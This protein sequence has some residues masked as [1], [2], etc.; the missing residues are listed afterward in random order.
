MVM[1]INPETGEFYDDGDDN[2]F[3][4][5]PFL[6]EPITVPNESVLLDDY[7]NPIPN[8]LPIYTPPPPSDPALANPIYSDTGGPTDTTSYNSDGTVNPG[9]T[10]YSGGPAD[11][12]L[13]AGLTSSIN[14]LLGSNFTGAQLARMAAVAG[15]GIAGLMGAFKPSIN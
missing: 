12:G 15:G 11:G 7:G 3:V 5:E 13:P 6:F 2:S 1:R 8:V 9:G 4:P 14:Q 10:A